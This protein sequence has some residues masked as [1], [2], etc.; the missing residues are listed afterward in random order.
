MSIFRDFFVK[1]KPVFTGITRGVGGFGFGK[2]AGG[3]GAA[4]GPLS[5]SGGS[6]N[7]DGLEP[8]NGYTYH[9]FTSPGT[10]TATG[11]GD[12]ELFLIGGGGAGG[13]G[14]G[15][16]GGAGALIYRTS[17]P[18]TEGSYPIVIGAGGIGT[19]VADPGPNP[20]SPTPDLHGQDSTALGF[21][22]PGGGGGS[23]S[24]TPNTISPGGSGGGKP[25]GPGSPTTA[26][27]YSTGTTWTRWRC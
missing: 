11:A 20:T 12:V 23:P 9:T 26:W 24:S 16:G 5:L 18:V 7:P 22:A 4:S 3:G 15:G 10:L 25:G 14:F 1:Q 17:V 8:G 13:G 21:T 6:V 19:W 2:A 27:W